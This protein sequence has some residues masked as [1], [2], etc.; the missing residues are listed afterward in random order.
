MPAKKITAK[1]DSKVVGS[2]AKKV[3]KKKVTKKKV[4][5]K[6]PVAK[7]VVKKK[8]VAKK[9]VAKKT[10]VKKVVKS[11][12]TVVKLEL[13]MDPI[14]TERIDKRVI[15]IST[16]SNCDHVPVG[17]NRL[18]GVLVIVIAILSLMVLSSAGTLDL[19]GV[20]RSFV[21]SIGNMG[22]SIVNSII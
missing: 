4:S 13:P 22:I 20:G 10:S 2:V 9:P 12:D 7:K 21:S 17:V 15:Y 8:S 18:V 14:S 1:S 19:F 11:T 3:T 16:C 5:V 6:K